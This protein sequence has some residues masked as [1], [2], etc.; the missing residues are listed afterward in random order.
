MPD[1]ENQPKRVEGRKIFLGGIVKMFSGA[2][3]SLSETPFYT[4]EDVSLRLKAMADTLP[5]LKM[6]FTDQFREEL[7]IKM[8]E[9]R[10]RMSDP[11]D[12]ANINR[13]LQELASP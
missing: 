2:E 5:T 6:A 1:F 3:I 4:N 8:I 7:K 12:I 13:M 10:D 11:A 9:H